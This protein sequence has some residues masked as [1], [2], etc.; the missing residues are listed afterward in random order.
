MGK[1]SQVFRIPP[2][3]ISRNIHIIGLSMRNVSF[4]HRFEREMKGINHFNYQE[5]R[6]DSTHNSPEQ[7]SDLLDFAL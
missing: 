3:G 1:K 4:A 5:K 6:I 2:I 7:M